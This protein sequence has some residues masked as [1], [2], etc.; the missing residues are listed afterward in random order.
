MPQFAPSSVHVAT[1]VFS[2]PK[3]AGFDYRAA[4]CMGAALTEMASASF[5]LDAGQSKSVPFSVTMPSVQGTYP[6]YLKVTSGGVLIGTFVATEDV[7]IF[8]PTINIIKIK[9]D[10]LAETVWPGNYQYTP[11]FP[12]PATSGWPS[13]T[14]LVTFQNP[15][16]VGLDYQAE[17]YL[18]PQATPLRQP[19]SASASF[20]IDAGQL[21]SIPFLFPGGLNVPNNLYNAYTMRL[22]ITSSGKFLPGEFILK[23][24]LP[25][26]AMGWDAPRILAGGSR[27]IVINWG[28]FEL[29]GVG[30]NPS[31]TS[32]HVPMPQ[33]DL[34]MFF[35]FFWGVAPSG[36][37]YFYFD[38]QGVPQL[39]VKHIH[40][41]DVLTFDFNT[42]RLTVVPSR[43]VIYP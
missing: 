29:P 6:V 3:S 35:E 1:P 15:T 37:G 36:P 32:T 9:W 28:S 10:Q 30:W 22:R 17:L 5:H 33:D 8:T 23:V 34:T 39:M 26:N 2:N 38:Y 27:N 20:H 40:Y 11:Y 19:A 43:E 31:A 4:L 24:I 21:K 13:H 41:D 18:A 14:A 16:P 12:D 25:A 7:V 42:Q